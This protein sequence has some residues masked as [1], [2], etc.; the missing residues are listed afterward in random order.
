MD[1]VRVF[2]TACGQATYNERHTPEGWVI[3]LRRRLI[4]EEMVDELAAELD[5]PEPNLVK[6]VDGACDSVYVLLG[7]ALA[8]GERPDESWTLTLRRYHPFHEQAYQ[9][10]DSLTW[11]NRVRSAAQETLINTSLRR[12][13]MMISSSIAHACGIAISAAQSFGTKLN[14]V[15]MRR[16]WEA[17]QAANME[18]VGLDGRILVVS[19][20]V[21]KPPG[22]V[23]P[24]ERI[25][26]ILRASGHVS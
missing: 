20:K 6:I 26:G 8:Y 24:D 7:T 22:W 16:C 13:A 18:K 14:P 17:V 19:G 23:P 1:D 5:A 25:R 12:G 4:Q 9:T 2:M 11:A 10:I 15:P 3:D 21:Q